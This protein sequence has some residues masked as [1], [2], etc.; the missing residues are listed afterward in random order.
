[1]PFDLDRIDDQNIP[2]SEPLNDP[3][4]LLQST[5]SE[6]LKSNADQH[7][8]DLDLSRATGVPAFAVD[9]DRESVQHRFDLDRINVKDLPNRAPNTA[10]FLTDFDNAVV[11]QDDI[12]NMEKVEGLLR[13]AASPL[14]PVAATRGLLD[15]VDLDKTFKNFGDTTTLGFKTQASGLVASGIEAQSGGID[16]LIPGA[17]LPPGMELEAVDL[18]REAASNL[19]IGSDEELQLARSEA[20]ESM[21]TT[22]RE[23]NAERQRLTP[24]DLNTVEQG[25][26]TGFESLVQQAPGIMAMAVTGG[27]AAPA[28]IFAGA[29]SYGESYGQARVEGLESQEATW[30]ATIDAA[31]EVGTELIPTKT[32]SGI[33]TAGVDDNLTKEGL[34]FLVQ[35]AGTEQL[36]TLGQSLNDYAFGLD[37][38]MIEA[39]TASEMVNIQL[40]RQAVTAVATIVA[41]GAQVTAA[42]TVRKG[43]DALTA[44]QQTIEER[45]DAEQQ[46]I[47]QI[48]DTVQESKLKERN[49]EAFRQFIADA[50]GDANTNLFIDGVQVQLYLRS[51][52]PDEIAADT[53][54][55]KLAEQAAEAARLGGDVVIPVADFATDLAG[56]E[57]FTALR[58]SMTMSAETIAP[59]R[60]EEQREESDAF[61]RTLVENAEQ[62][63]SEYAEAQEIYNTVRDQLV[64]TGRVSPQAARTMAELVPAWATAHAT[65]TGSTVA[66]VYEAAGL[67]I[68]GPLTGERARLEAERDLLEQD[69][70]ELFIPRT[71]TADELDQH[72]SVEVVKLSDTFNTE[73]DELRARLPGAGEDV[74]QGYG[75]RPLVVRRSDGKHLIY[76]GHHRIAAARERGDESLAMHVIHV[77]DFEPTSD[78][79]SPPVDDRTD[80]NILD[81]L[82]KQRPN[83]APQARG[84]YDP[85]NTV[86][87]LTE[88]SN[89]STFLH[90]FA[91]FMYEME[92]SAGTRNIE[93]I[94]QW[95]KRNAEDVAK[96]A[97][98]ELKGITPDEVVSYLDDG[99]TGSSDKDKA[100]R[101]A[102]HEQFARGFETYLMEGKS[103]SVELRNAFRTFAQWLTQIYRRIKGDLN[104][105]LD[106]QM[107]QVFDRLIAT[108]DQIAAAEARAQYEPLFTDA[109]MA[110]MT[111]DEFDQYKRNQ[112]KVKGTQSETLRDKL[113]A[114]LTRKT[115]KWWRD[116]LRDFVDEESVTLAA[117]KVH[118]TRDALRTGDIKLDK[119]V[120]K[121]MVGEQITDARDRTFVRI[122]NK[123][124]NMTAPSSDGV[125]PDEAAAFYGYASGAE[126]LND[127][128]TAPT[129]K[130]AAQVRAEA[131][132]VD[133]Y[134]DILNDGTIEREAD[135]AVQ[136]EERG[137]LILQEL[138][139]LSRGTSQPLIERQAL[140]DLAAE[141]IGKLSFRNI[142]PGKYRKAEIRAASESA[143]ALARG[144][145]MV[146]ARA[147]AQQALNYYLGME[148][149]AARNTVTKIVDRMSRYNKKAVREEIQKAGNEYWGQLTKILNRFEFRKSASLKQVDQLNSDINSW[150]RT[151][152]AEDGDAL[153]LSPAVLDETYVVH[154]KNVPFADLQGINDSVKNI[155]HVAR[156][157]NKITALDEEVEFKKLV[158]DWTDHI[159]LQPTRFTAQ[160]TDVVEGRNWGRWAMAQMTKIPFLA[161]W[162]DG[163]DRAGLSHR[164]L[165]QPFTDAYDQELNLWN[166][167]G[168]VVMDAIGGRS[169]EDMRRHNTKLF[170]PAIKSETNDGNLYGHQVLSVALNVGNAGNLKKMLLGEGWASPDR[171]EEISINNPRLQAVLS[172]MTKDDWEL[173][174]LI[175]D[176]MG[177]LYPQLAEVHRRTT[178]L[179]PPKVEATPIET[180]FGSFNGGYYPV[181]YDPKRDQRAQ[182]NEDRLNAETES[183][184]SNSSSIQASVNAGA[185]NERTGYYAPI[186]LSLD[187][188]GNHFQETIHYVTH[189][190]P[191]RQANKLLRNKQV[192]S[193]IT[194]KLGPEEFAQLRP[195]L[196]DI[197]K[198][199]RESPTKTFWD[200]LLGKL[201][202]G[203]TLGVMGF[204]A[205]TGIIQISGLSNTIAEL[206]LGP[207]YQAMRSI[208]GNTTDMK[209][210][211]EFAVENS[212]VMQHRATNFDREIKNALSQLEGRRGILAAAQEASMK[213]IA[214]I[215]TYMV[216]LP[217]WHAAY[218]KSMT[219]DGDEAKAYR[220][221]DFVVESV[222]GS[223]ATKDLAQILRGQSETSRMFTMFMTFF[224][225]LWNLERDLVKGARSG[226]YSTTTVAAKAMFLFTVPVLF[227]M[228]LRGELGGE[229][230]EPGEQ[231]QK[232]LTSLALFPVQSVPFIRDIASG[233]S[234]EFGYNISPLAQ[235]L[236]TGVR[237]IPE[238]VTR[239][240]TDEDITKGQAKGSV[241]FIGAAAGI[242]GV[243]QAWAT[244]EHLYDVLVDGEELTFREFLF[245]PERD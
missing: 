120:V 235:L 193:A 80:Q 215:Q 110:G 167:V 19:G 78:K 118:R 21:L 204:K 30:K 164:I 27:Q 50:D 155:E 89:L 20:V 97:S 144:D 62:N 52:L 240:F 18:S 230:D 160:R 103:P 243:S 220:F 225:S 58:D 141:N 184:F 152:M 132:M 197:A 186:R 188:V 237:S 75:D 70:D 171:P 59:F 179:T 206:G 99:A 218:I 212:K 122:P 17:A 66:E 77:N 28:L 91:H 36:A 229:D 98:Q 76:D 234:G 1:M 88:A 23:T 168:S 182:E 185:T 129:L 121:E 65:Q 40:Q 125:H 9:S 26:R 73:S 46:S 45:S 117:E 32:L 128:I 170:I 63:V 55:Q 4:S 29:Q 38:Q 145:T 136:N 39:E 84:F 134:G 102:V 47:D 142:H 245:G 74:V 162:L 13:L 156:Y 44:K 5:V 90:E 34:K 194:S 25:I 239:G 53:T 146:A 93:K 43:I 106:D 244:G 175:W 227:E 209:K 196:N 82:F 127:L 113:I 203:T 15:D 216:D 205:S 187:V 233:A 210:A 169:K 217:T 178:G 138:K 173:V 157:S 51:K 11:A 222:Q 92:L 228:M 86:I 214:L 153:V 115:K 163:G 137:K 123:L 191:V 57:H 67:T 219:E 114:Q 71:P 56:T 24:D 116:E 6:A 135:E 165:V 190:D 105:N 81:E 68:E 108:E 180:E 211:W 199:G 213:H 79:V 41:G 60:R 31:I 112:D 100:I 174:Q 231:L 111:Q 131:R 2:N 49:A 176:Q 232:V 7:A 201:R 198:D 242:P 183:M 151:R 226:T 69:I 22:I 192:A 85:E 104:V 200:D 241:K 140:K 3:D 207:T 83:G 72:S 147:K 223:G 189:H 224:S 64:D 107:R 159:D 148:A 119:V 33:L 139:T 202:F 133:K 154:W 42:T 35:E 101:R 208:L 150:A 37:E 10:K 130:E 87:R 158:N 109:A 8:K 124:R 16:D 177:T 48:N 172:H 61:V 95:Y 143:A 195:W 181:K 94:N 14:V 221:A 12:G 54:L 149:T 161:S 166:D 236:D 238:V 96:E 126:M